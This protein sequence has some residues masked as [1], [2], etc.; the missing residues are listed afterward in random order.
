MGF[1]ILNNAQLGVAIIIMFDQSGGGRDD[2]ASSHVVARGGQPKIQAKPD[3]KRKIFTTHV[4]AA[5]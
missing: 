1:F 2:D 3:K 4:Y 5:L